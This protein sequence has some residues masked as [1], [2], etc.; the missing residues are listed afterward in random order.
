M[1]WVSRNW[2]PSSSRRRSR[3][4]QSIAGEGSEGSLLSLDAEEIDENIDKD[5]DRTGFDFIIWTGD[6]ARHD[7]DNS[8]PR[9]RQEIY[10]LNKWCLDLLHEKFPGVPVVPNIGNNDIFPHNIMWPGPNDVIAAYTDIW[11]KEVPEYELHTFQLGGYFTQEVIPNRLAVISLNT[12]YFYDS[13]K[14]VDGC[15]KIKRERRGKL[16]KSASIAGQQV[17]DEDSEVDDYLSSE[18]ISAALLKSKDPGTVQLLWLDAQL[19]QYRR[20]GMAVHIIGHVPPTGG[21]YFPRC[22]DAYTD[23]VLHYQEVV[24]GQHFGHMNVDAFFVQE[25]VE[26]LKQTEKKQGKK[27]KGREMVGGKAASRSVD[28]EREVE[29]QQDEDEDDSDDNEITTAALSDDI[30]KDLMILPKESKTNESYYSYFFAVPGIVPTFLPATRIWTYNVS[31]VEID[32][33]GQNVELPRVQR[34]RPSEQLLLDEDEEDDGDWDVEELSPSSQRVFSTEGGTAVQRSAVQ[35]SDLELMSAS[36]VNV[37]VSHDQDQDQQ[38]LL[39]AHRVQTL[40]R[41][42]R[43]PKHGKR[44]RK[45][46]KDSDYPRFDSPH[47]PARS[48]QQMSLLGYSQWTLDLDQANKEWEEGHHK[49]G[50]KGH[51]VEKAAQGEPRMDRNDSNHDGPLNFQLEYATYRPEKLWGHLASLVGNQT[52][53]EPA[54]DDMAAPPPVPRH[55]LVR[56]LHQRG[57]QVSDI[58]ATP[59][60]PASKRH[61]RLHLPA[62]LKHLTDWH[63]DS[64]TVGSVLHLARRL[65][66]DDDLWKRFKSRL[67]EGSGYQG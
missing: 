62:S 49:K 60:R 28:D 21:N 38:D 2:M 3:R 55:L 24:V 33:V 44:H 16:G 40:R 41:K 25:D 19:D 7:I 23:I 58:F 36:S 20:R 64:F 29:D 45:H 57:L 35:R 63:L 39:F 50:D 6:S 10:D 22:F 56:E 4:K 53:S 54:S 18:G 65:V 26:A 48:N 11:K 67:Y 31:G 1:E 5:D 30:R 42:H 51:C 66:K 15:K 34:Y 8:Y 9:T 13:N 14:V 32:D 46:R 37:A 43:R 17:V 12:L 52:N 47:S 59:S 27:S 61:L